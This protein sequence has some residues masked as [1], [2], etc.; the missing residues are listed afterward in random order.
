MALFPGRFR[1]P[2]GATPVT[3]QW[4][5]LGFKAWVD[6]LDIGRWVAHQA[7]HTLATS[8]LRHE[9]TSPTSAATSGMS[10]TGW[11]STTSPD[12]RVWRERCRDDR[13]T[14]RRDHQEATLAE[15]DFAWQDGWEYPNS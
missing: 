15:Q 9:A 10:P 5:H 12:L 7:R 14:G 13:D 1:N 2:D 3:Y 11:P 8:L 4:F 6:E